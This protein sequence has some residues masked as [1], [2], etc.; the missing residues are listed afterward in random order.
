MK[1]LLQVKNVIKT[2]V[3]CERV[4]WFK[5]LISKGIRAH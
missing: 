1:K 4:G 3:S 5:A 2:N